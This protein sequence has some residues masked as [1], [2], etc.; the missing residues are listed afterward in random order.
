LER[1]S[2]FSGIGSSV[3]DLHEVAD[4]A[5]HAGERR[6]LLVLGAAT[7]PTQPESAQGT[8]MA[9]GLSDLRPDLRDPEPGH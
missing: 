9:L 8:A 2:C 5:E 7:D 4:L 3:L 1:F 6:R